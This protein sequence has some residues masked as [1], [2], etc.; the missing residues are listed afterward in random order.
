ML[1]HPRASKR[2]TVILT[3]ILVIALFAGCGGGG[4]SSPSTPA[5]SSTTAA[6]GSSS[7]PQQTPAE[8]VGPVNKTGYPIMN[9]DHTF[10]ITHSIATTDKTGSWQDKEFIH[11][12]TRDTG[13][14]LE[15]TGIPEQSYN[16]QVGIIIASNNLP[17]VFIGEPPNFSQFITSFY[18]VTDEAIAEYVPTLAQFYGQN[19]DYRTMSVFPDGK[20]YGLPYTQMDGIIASKCLSINQTWLDKVGA[21][22]PNTPDE[23]FDVLMK[24]KT[25]DPNG[26]GQNDEIPYSF[27][28]D[29][30]RDDKLFGM[31][32]SGF[33]LVND[34]DANYR[35]LMVENGK[36]RFY[37]SDPRYLEFLQY[38][39]KL[40]VNGLLDPSGFTQEEVDMIA[41]GSSNLVGVFPNYSYDDIT[42]GEY[43]D[44]FTHL[45]PLQD[46]DGNRRYMQSKI[47]GNLTPNRFVITLKCQ[48][49]E[50]ML[51][52]YEYANQSF[53]N[54]I[55]GTWGPEGTA[56]AKLADGSLEKLA[57][58]L[59]DGYTS[60]A[61]I[62][63]SFSL[64]VKGFTIWMPED[65]QQFAVT[66]DREKKLLARQE[67]FV[68]Y[69]MNE[70]IPK[71]QNDPA[72]S[73]EINILLTEIKSYMD[74]FMAEAV[75]K[76]IDQ[77]KWDAH[78]QSC[79][80]LNVDTY[81]ELQQK[82]YD[83]VAK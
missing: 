57:N 4:Q 68:P 10:K 40:H 21:Q 26:N 50:A 73:Q 51:R 18:E 42:V 5:P 34:D 83:L 61:E 39:N 48:Y 23:L 9:E 76:G 13:L 55:L 22:L 35:F 59:P 70:Y 15:L 82:Y 1:Y 44:D 52:M 12:L 28:K 64:G 56:W 20:M 19:A 75:L 29:Q 47:P 54:R 16:E 69:I 38:V 25:E 31:L 71:G 14:K 74:N 43:A 66:T 80:R 24:F 77:A 49:P 8:E 67:P 33:G 81:V 3:L 79:E 30:N 7:Q 63:H 60:Y 65:N 53:E 45:L 36:V 72:D 11:N 2:A 78:V 32:L 58:P 46:K 37:P 62:R 6:Q 17:D 27:Y 41:K